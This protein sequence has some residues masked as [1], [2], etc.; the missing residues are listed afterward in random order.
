MLNTYMYEV[1]HTNYIIRHRIHC[2]CISCP[3]RTK[4][5]VVLLPA[6]PETGQVTFKHLKVVLSKNFKAQ[7]IQKLAER[8]REDDGLDTPTRPRPSL[9]VGTATHRSHQE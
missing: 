4:R 5:A 1:K 9:E 6:A 8:A 7:L 2:V 3:Y